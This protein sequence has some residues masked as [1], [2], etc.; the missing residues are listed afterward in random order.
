MVLSASKRKDIEQDLALAMK[1]VNL[2]TRQHENSLYELERKGYMSNKELYVRLHMGDV[3]EWFLAKY[4]HFVKLAEKRIPR[5]SKIEY[6]IWCSISQKNCLKP[7]EKSLVYCLQ[8][9]ENEVIYFSGG[10]WDLVLNNLYI[11]LDKKDAERFEEQ[12]HALGLED[13]FQI[14]EGKYKGLYPNIESEIIHSWER[15]FN[16]DEWNIFDVQ[17]NLWQIKQEWVRHI[18]HP[19][20]DL[21]EIAADMAQFDP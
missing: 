8:V 5:P 17:A 9:P 13:G 7:I 11:P 16:I 6:P 1:I 14:I 19:G 2:Y 12:I 21:F 15:I 20:E 10:K 3:A 18:I 4:N